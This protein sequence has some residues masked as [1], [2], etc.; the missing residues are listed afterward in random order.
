M[1]TKNRWFRLFAV[2]AALSLLTLAGCGDDD[3]ATTTEVPTTEAPATTA[4]PATTVAMLDEVDVAGEAITAALAEWAPVIGAADL[5]E[6]L[7][8][9]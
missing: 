6:N 7:S 3:A 5:F 1:T 4:A 9:G 8:D 2:A